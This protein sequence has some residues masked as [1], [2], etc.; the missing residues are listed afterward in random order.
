MTASP[1]KKLAGRGLT[2]GGPSRVWLGE[3]HV[4][5][6]LTRGYV[7]VYRRFFFKD[8]Q[9]FIV[10]Q[11]QIG[12]I[13]NA[14][15][16]AGVA[17]FGFLALALN[18]VGTIVMLCL[19]APFAVALLINVILGPTCSFHVRTAVQTERLPAVS[20][21]RSAEKF[22]AGI[23]PL[24]AAAQGEVPGEQFGAELERLQNPAGYAASAP[25]VMGP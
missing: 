15:W 22:M 19:A 6:V 20:R 23:E 16:G 5:L 21:V 2:W 3:D 18:D 1:Y 17:F 10:R 4:L 24:I 13:W 7:E 12:K 9:A 25:P 14:V 8:I 11:T